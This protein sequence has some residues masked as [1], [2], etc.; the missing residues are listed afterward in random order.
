[1]SEGSQNWEWPFGSPYN[2]VYNTLQYVKGLGHHH[3]HAGFRALCQNDEALNPN[4]INPK[5]LDS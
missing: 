1:M 3:T 2:K 5:V 4:R